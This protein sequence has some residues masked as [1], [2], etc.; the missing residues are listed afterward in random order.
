MKKRDVVEWLELWGEWERRGGNFV[1]HLQPKSPMLT[2]GAVVVRDDSPPAPELN[3]DEARWICGK[4]LVVKR[5]RPSHYA[6]LKQVHV[7]QL[8]I[9]R[10]ASLNKTSRN[11][12]S[13]SYKEALGAFD[14]LLELLQVA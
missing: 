2:I 14:M 10:I 1:R 3:D 6:I 8:S 13:E 5:S 9:V 7:H 12:A 11:R 4:L